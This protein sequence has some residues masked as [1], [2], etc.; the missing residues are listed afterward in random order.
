MHKFKYLLITILTVSYNTINCTDVGYPRDIHN[1]IKYGVNFNELPEYIAKW[2][3]SQRDKEFG[4]WNPIDNACISG[5]ESAF[6]FLIS[7]GATPI[8]A[9]LPMLIFGEN[10]KQT[11]AAKLLTL[12][13]DIDRVDIAD[14][15]GKIR[16]YNSSPIESDQLKAVELGQI[17]SMLVRYQAKKGLRMA[18]M[19]AIY[20]SNRGF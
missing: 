3:E 13:N 6:D 18:F 15:N 5:N 4:L 8:K 1:A 19:G 10:P 11:F 17:A 16:I 20:S 7:I 14:I 12:V 9:H 2:Y